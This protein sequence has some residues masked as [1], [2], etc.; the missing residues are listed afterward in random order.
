MICCPLNLTDPASG[1][2]PS[3]TGGEVEPTVSLLDVP[4]HQLL[5]GFQPEVA[6]DL[7]APVEEVGGQQD[8]GGE[9]VLLRHPVGLQQVGLDGLV[10]QEGLSQAGE[11]K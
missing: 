8:G 4:D 6:A 5:A 3:P 10:G 1:E 9:A 11:L 7:T 2:P